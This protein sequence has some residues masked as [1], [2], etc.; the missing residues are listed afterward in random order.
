MNTTVATIVIVLAV[1]LTL[2]SL[3]TA[4]RNRP[5]GMVLLVG[6]AVLEVAVLV[7]A[8]FVIAAVAGGAGP[9]DKVTLFGY[10]GGE[11]LIPPA[12]VFLA[13]AERSRWGPGI[14]AV[15]GFAIAVM[16]GRLLQIWQGTA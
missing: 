10:V 3:V 15:A 2:A 12:G 5:M 9:A 16:T 14:L 11:V 7:Q 6:F 1:L 13:L 4:I 8:G